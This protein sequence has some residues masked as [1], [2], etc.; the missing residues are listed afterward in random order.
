MRFKKAVEK[1]EL[2]LNN[3]QDIAELNGKDGTHLKE[4]RLTQSDREAVIA[5]KERHLLHMQ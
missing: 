2:Q 4:F 5:K 3:I 1:A